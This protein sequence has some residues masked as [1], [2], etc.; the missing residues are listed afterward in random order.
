MWKNFGED[1][2]KFDG[3]CWELGENGLVSFGAEGVESAWSNDR[4]AHDQVSSEVGSLP[5]RVN[6]VRPC[7]QQS[8]NLLMATVGQG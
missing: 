5:D 1:V 2:Y 8:I 4:L 7:L 3:Y 6:L